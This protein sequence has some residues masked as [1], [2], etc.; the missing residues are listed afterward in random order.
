[1]MEYMAQTHDYEDDM[2]EYIAQIYDDEDDGFEVFVGWIRHHSKELVRCKNCKYF[3][4][5]STCTH[6]H[7]DMSYTQDVEVDEQDY[8]SYAERIEE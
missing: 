6:Q 5:N 3:T 2:R 8:C 4:V 1:M 7:W